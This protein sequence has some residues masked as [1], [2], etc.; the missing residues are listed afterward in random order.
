MFRVLKPGTKVKRFCDAESNIEIDEREIKMLAA[1]GIILPIF[2]IIFLGYWL[3]RKRIIDPQYARPANQ[4]VFYVAIPA[5]LLNEIAQAPFKSNFQISAVLCLV[6][7]LALQLL[8]GLTAMLVLDTPRHR[9]GTFLQS[10]FHGNLGYMAY[11]IAYY[12]LGKEDFAR[13]AILSSFLMVEQNCLAIWALT[14]FQPKHLASRH[15]QGWILLKNISHNPI[16]LAVI[17]GMLYS[18][19]GLPVPAPIARGLD[20][21]SGMA[22]PTALL[23]IG[24]SLSFGS[25]RSML[26]DIASIGALKLI[27]LPTLGYL[28][29][30]LVHVPAVL[31]PPGIILL[32]APPATVTYVMAGELGG[33]PELAATSISALTL[34]SAFTYSLFLA[35]LL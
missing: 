18:A 25:L 23:L 26:S 22:L 29:M 5:M 12:A 30:V 7:A 1:L 9:R 19:T 17:A 11:A 2:S 27:G 3:K 33:D 32:A 20:I 24:G 13:T 15:G 34:V 10:S 21:L 16:I 28:L 6:V 14:T 31:I 8:L 4:I 35:L